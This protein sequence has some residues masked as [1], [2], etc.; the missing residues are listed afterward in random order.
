MTPSFSYHPHQQTSNVPISQEMNFSPLTSPAILPQHSRESSNSNMSVPT[1]SDMTPNQI[2]EQYEQLERAKIMI[3]RRLSELHKKRPR[4][5][6]QQQQKQLQQQQ[7]HF[8]RRISGR[9]YSLIT[10][11][12]KK[13][14]MLLKKVYC[15]TLQI[16]SSHCHQLVLH[17]LSL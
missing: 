15:V 13:K 5:D 2:Y 8:H 16:S 10:M 3:T 14:N 9:V 11:E 12:I 7:Q 17:A 6:E 1:G 4:E